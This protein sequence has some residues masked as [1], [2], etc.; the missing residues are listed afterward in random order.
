MQSKKGEERTTL[1]VVF[2]LIVLVILII[3][4]YKLFQSKIV[5]GVL[6]GI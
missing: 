2:I 5:S 6:K 4:L 1:Y 3:I